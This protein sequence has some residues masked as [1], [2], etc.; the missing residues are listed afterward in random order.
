[1]IGPLLFL[2][3]I[4]GVTSVP[5]SVGSQL[6]VYADRILL[7]RPI[8]CQRDFAALQD[9]IN[10]LDT[11]VNTNS[12]QFNTSKCKYMVVSR[13][14]SSITPASLILQGHYLECVECFKYLGLLLSTD[15]SW[16]AHVETVCS[17]AKKL[18]GL[19]YRKYYQY[20]EPQILFQ[21]NI[22]LVRPHLEYA[23]PE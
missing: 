20:A 17:K 6:T 22:S 21:L 1:M 23:S 3:Y 8:S 19:L 13:K 16:T 5:L 12:L 7:Y 2:I 10:K 9:D 15:L 18:L 14:R 11:W 4:D